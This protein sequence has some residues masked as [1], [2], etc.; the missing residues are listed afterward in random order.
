MSS[1]RGRKKGSKNK[2]KINSKVEDNK[3]SLNK[4]IQLRNN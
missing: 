3:E 4:I 1:K 2:Q